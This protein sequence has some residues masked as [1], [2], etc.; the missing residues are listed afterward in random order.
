MTSGDLALDVTD[1]FCGMGGSSTGLHEAGFTIR[2]AANHWDR[3]ITTHAANHPDTEHLCADG[4]ALDLRYLPRTRVLWAS[5]IC[6]ELSP[7]GGRRRRPV[8]H[9]LFEEFG[10][11]PDA[12]FERTRTTFW[13]VLRAAEIFGYE[14]ILIENVVEAFDWP[15][16]PVFLD[17]LERLGYSWQV[18]SVSAAHVGDESNTPAPQWRDRLYLRALRKGITGTRLEPRP[19]AFCPTCQQVV[20]ARQVWKP[21]RGTR[22]G[23][24][25]RELPVGKYDQQYFYACPVPLHGRVEPFVAPASVAIDWSDLGQRIGDRTRPLAPRTMQRLRLGAELFGSDA[26]AAFL[27]G[28]AGNTSDAAS[29]HRRTYLRAWPALESPVQTQTTDAQLGLV[30]SG[31]FVTMLRNH[32]GSLPVADPLPTFTSG[33]FHHS[34]VIPYRKGATPYPV[35]AAPLSTAATHVQHG[36]LSGLD[37]DLG[38][39]HFRMLKPREAA[40]AQRFPGSYVITGNQGEQQTQAGNAVAVNVARWIGEDTARVLDGTPSPVF[41]TTTTRRTPRAPLAPVAPVRRTPPR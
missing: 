23:K 7:A 24:W 32:G 16:M 35:Q 11:V 34:L 5:P 19:P 3:A 33:G 15:L 2:L 27:M 1:F 18:V 26:G 37:G 31:A 21:I 40:N 8:E 13:E 28:A 41:E 14:A 39:Y 25:Y 20:P 30:T 38:D 29:G 10:H 6:T 12:A 36:V 9:D 22:A 4:Q 17:G